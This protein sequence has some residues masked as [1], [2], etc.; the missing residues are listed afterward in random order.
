MLLA[1]RVRLQGIIENRARRRPGSRGVHYD[2][3]HGMKRTGTMSLGEAGLPGGRAEY[4]RLYP[5]R[6]IV[7]LSSTDRHVQ[8]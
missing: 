8:V 7:S 1:G 5:P 6:T 3:P 4:P 2:A